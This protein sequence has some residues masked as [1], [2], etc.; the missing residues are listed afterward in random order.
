MDHIGIDV[1]K[2]KIR[3]AFLR[4]AER[5]SSVRPNMIG[6]TWS[7]T[8][9]SPSH[10]ATRFNGR[11][12]GTFSSGSGSAEVSTTTSE[13]T[14]SGRCAAKRMPITPPIESPTKCA[15]CQPKLLNQLDRVSGERLEVIT[16]LG[17]RFDAFVR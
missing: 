9:D 8:S 4:K 3:F 7:A 1:H 16:R 13:R 6:I 12:F 14:S 2:K 5:S 15:G 10:R 11:Y 17:H